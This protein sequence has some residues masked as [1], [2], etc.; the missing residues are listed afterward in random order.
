MDLILYRLTR[1]VAW[2]AVSQ[3]DGV[4]LC[5]WVT[6]QLGWHALCNGMFSDDCVWN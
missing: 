6:H 2:L 5:R 4:M 3:T 1:T